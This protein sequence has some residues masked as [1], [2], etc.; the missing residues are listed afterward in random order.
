MPMGTLYIPRYPVF[1]GDDM[2]RAE[3]MHLRWGDF[4][5]NWNAVHSDLFL[6]SDVDSF[7]SCV[8]NALRSTPSITHLRF[9]R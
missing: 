4:C 9:D 2:R 8:L 7:G 6:F 5:L 3:P 1:T